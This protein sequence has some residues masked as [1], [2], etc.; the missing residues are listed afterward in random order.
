MH[1]KMI[2]VGAM[3][4]ESNRHPARQAFNA[5][6]LSGLRIDGSN[7]GDKNLEAAPARLEISFQY[8]GAVGFIQ[9]YVAQFP[10]RFELAVV[11]GFVVPD[12]QLKIAAQSVVVLAMIVVATGRLCCRRF[13]GTIMASTTT[14]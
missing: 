13:I 8:A 11:V 1:R 9:H 3:P 5:R 14:D 10:D 4:V 12:S 6:R 2:N 7:L